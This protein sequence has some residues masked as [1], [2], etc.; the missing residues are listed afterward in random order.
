M[1]LED[2][3]QQHSEIVE[4]LKSLVVIHKNALEEQDVSLKIPSIRKDVYICFNDLCKLNEMLIA[5]DGE[6]KEA[7]ETLQISKEK[8]TRLVKKESKLLEDKK[9]WSLEPSQMMAS[10]IPITVESSYRSLLNSYIELVG[11]SNTVLVNDRTEERALDREQLMRSVGL[12]KA[13]QDEISKDIKRLEAL[14]RDFHKDQAF[15][16]KELRDKQARIRYETNSINGDLAK[17]HHSKMKILSKVGLAIPENQ[18]SFLSQKL[19]HLQLS[20]ENTK[21]TQEQEDIADHAVEFMDMKIQS[22]QDQLTHK[23]EDSSSLASQRNLWGECIQIVEDLEHRLE[24]ALNDKHQPTAGQINVWLE[25][26]IKNLNSVISVCEGEIITTLVMD[27]KSA[28][29]KALQEVSSESVQP[30]G[31]PKIN[32]YPAPSTS[33]SHSHSSP[34]FLV[35][36]K[37]PPKIGI[38]GETVDP[39]THSNTMELE[40]MDSYK[41]KRDKRD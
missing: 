41:G 35:A 7:I 6:I 37:S 38:T 20:D 28:I 29:E 39:A 5:C 16:S 40:D 24:A 36:S 10:R 15:I 21:K 32:R 33:P 9:K 8:F 31:I 14:L 4:F 2:V 3:L 19:F 34:P 11:V 1:A 27:E 18:G 26:T 25:S 12:L 22:L 30:L 17:I 13:S 23:K